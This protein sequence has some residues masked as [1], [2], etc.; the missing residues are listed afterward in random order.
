M[1]NVKLSEMMTNMFKKYLASS[2]VQGLEMRNEADTDP[3]SWRPML[4]AIKR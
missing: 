3:A 4:S 1:E 2:T